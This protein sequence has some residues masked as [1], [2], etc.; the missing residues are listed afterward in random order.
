ML[1]PSW[2]VYS[3][4][5]YNHKQVPVW[6][7]PSSLALNGFHQCEGVIPPQGEG[8]AVY[9]DLHEP[10]LSS[11]LQASSLSGCEKGSLN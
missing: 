6:S 10:P 8:F 7:L 4:S 3:L 11:F 9:A 1:L 2:I 5:C